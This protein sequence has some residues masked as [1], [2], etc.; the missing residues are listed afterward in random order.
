MTIVAFHQADIGEY[1]RN[2]QE[3]TWSILHFYIIRNLSLKIFIHVASWA[4]SA[5]HVQTYISE[6]KW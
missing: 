6:K 5:L 2:E 1:I 4:T 3:L